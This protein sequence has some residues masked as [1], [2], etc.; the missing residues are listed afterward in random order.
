MKSKL[1][2]HP[3]AGQ[4]G[5]RAALA[6]I[7]ALVTVAAHSEVIGPYAPDADT[8]HLWHMN[9]LAVPVVDV[10]TGGTHLTALRNGATLG[11]VSYSGF[12]LAVSTSDGGVDAT[13]DAGRDAYLS[14]RP[15][16]S[17]LGD[18]VATTYAGENGAFTYEALVRIDFDPYTVFNTNATSGAHG[19][20]M[21]ILNLDADENTNRVCQFRLVPIGILKENTE[22]LLEF[23]NLARD[24][25][26]QSLTAKI[27]TTGPDGI[28]LSNWY[29]VAVTYDG[30]P[31]QPDNL[32]FYWSL[33]DS[34]HTTA[35]LIG[36]GRLSNNLPVGCQPDLAIGQTGRQS[37]VNPRPNNNF[38]GLIDEVRVS[39]VA[40]SPAQMIFGGP[41]A[42]VAAPPA[43]PVTETAAAQPPT[44]TD[45]PDPDR[46]KWDGAAWLI[47]GALLIIAGLLGWLAFVLKRLVATA[48]TNTSRST[49]PITENHRPIIEAQPVYRHAEIPVATALGTTVGEAMAALTQ[50]SHRP[51]P[52]AQLLSDDWKKHPED[53]VERHTSAIDLCAEG[54]HGV[55]RKVGLQDLIQMECLNQRSS[56]LEITTEKLT[57]RIYMERGE[58]LHATAG[59]YSGEKAF[60][61]LFSQRGGEFNLRPFE[62]PAERTIQCHWIHLLLE[63]ARQ[64]DEDTV[65][66]TAGKLSFTRSTTNAE[67]ILDM[68]GL[69]AD[70]PQVTE[71][72]VCSSEGKPMFNS[73]CRDQSGRTQVC[74]DLLRVAKSASTL[75]PVGEFDQIEILRPESKTLIRGDQECHLLIGM[76][77][78]ANSLTS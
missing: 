63:A 20:F 50:E 16:V 70:H 53:N 31:N 65:H 60:I 49:S 38:I 59:K 6:T 15:L 12:G 22:P 76:E 13:S 25:S 34:H 74:L 41:A 58:I 1:P 28:A 24:K 14:A 26:P 27:P 32:K 77:N 35:N 62:R 56:I 2:T 66:I 57:G 48:A 78:D 51:V 44:V 11:N 64:R 30:K 18:N 7:V 8:I 19:N 69:L 40:R 75:L 42:L 21:Q 45:S 37:P 4:P 23:I 17:D 47:A 5:N 33:L 54:F 61:K 68:A 73:K 10:G 9:E 72:L 29:H 43:P 52:Q 67:D 55:L 36:T 3:A 39:G 71:I 46:R